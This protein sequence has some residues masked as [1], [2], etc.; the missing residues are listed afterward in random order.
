[1]ALRR[2]CAVRSQ[3]RGEECTY[4]HCCQGDHV[5]YHRGLNYARCM[6]PGT[7]RDVWSPDVGSCEVASVI[8]QCAYQ[9]GECTLSG[10]C[11]D[12]GHSCFMKNPRYG[13]CMRGCTPGVGDFVDWSC[14][15][16][17]RLDDEGVAQLNASSESAAAASGVT[18]VLLLLAGIAV[19]GCCGC[20]AAYM[21]RSPESNPRRKLADGPDTPGI[22]LEPAGLHGECDSREDADP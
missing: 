19:G 10:C 3:R 22:E 8:T 13:R 1:M 14:E 5:C 17:M 15:L 18:V 2:T 9:G 7:C 20:F 6:A 12:E 21:L 4:T 16:H 11:V